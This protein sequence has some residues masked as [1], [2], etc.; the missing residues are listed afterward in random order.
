VIVQVKWKE[1]EK[2]TFFDQ[3]CAL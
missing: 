1:Y 3:Y 2:L